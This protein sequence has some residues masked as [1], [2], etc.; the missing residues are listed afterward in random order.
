MKNPNEELARFAEKTRWEDLPESVTNEVKLILIDSIGCALAGISVAPGEM[1]VSLA[2]RLG[3]PGESSIIGTGEKVSCINAAF[4]NGEL[5]RA[6]DY[7]AM[8]T[9]GHSPPYVIPPA[10]AIAESKKAS[11]RDLILALAI[12]FEISAR[13]SKG[14]Q[15]GG[16]SFT[17]TDVKSFK[18]G[19]R[20]GGA[21]FNFGAAAGAG[22]IL[23]LDLR[24]MTNALGMAGHLCQVLT[25]TKFTFGAHRH[26]AKY[27][28]A[29][30]QNTGAVTAA[31]LAGMGYAGDTDVL[32]PEYGFWKFCGYSGWK[33]ELVTAELGKTWY[34]P[35]VNYKRYPCCGMLHTALDCFYN[36]I[37]RNDLKPSDIASVKIMGHPVLE[38]P[39]F[40]NREL[41]NVVDVQFGMHYVI[42]LAAFRVKI[43][44]EWQDLDKIKE[45]EIIEFSKKVSFQ[46]HPDYARISRQDPS[47]QLSRVEVTAGLET[48]QEERTHSRGTS[49]TTLALTIDEIAEKFKHNAS[50]VL[51][52]T[53]AESAME[54]ILKLERYE[55]IREVLKYFTVKD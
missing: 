55:D 24:E 31:L 14:L 15:G 39:L 3:G 27:G 40:T 8:P 33:P 18:V 30:W 19:T 25:N 48:Y 5:I 11:G 51:T 26:M 53:Q 22:K 1:A 46:A 9:G 41:A 47:S 52:K 29:G 42:S 28:V 50:R 44:A 10:L 49:G 54:A 37:D 16:F 4:A 21:A 35:R 6:L 2:R 34:T 32:D 36:I 43:G 20:G 17:G 23:G 7:D 13:I 38:L 12:G 45:P